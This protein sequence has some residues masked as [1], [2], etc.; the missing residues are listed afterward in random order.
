MKSNLTPAKF[1]TFS[2]AT[3]FLSILGAI[4]LGEAFLRLG[5]GIQPWQNYPVAGEPVIH[6]PDAVLGWRNRPGNYVFSLTSDSGNLVKMSFVTDG[7]R[8]TDVSRQAR[9]RKI[10]ILGCSLTQGWTISDDETYA[11]KLQARFP[12]EEVSNYGTGGYGTYQSLLLLERLLSKPGPAPGIVVYGFASFHE[13]RNV[14]AWYWLKLLSMFSHRGHIGVPYCDLDLTI[15][16]LRRHPPE[17]YPN[18]PF[19]RSL[20][21]FVLAEESFA[22]FESRQRVSQR[23]MVTEQLLLEMGRLCRDKG[24]RLLVA[25]L[26][27]ELGTTDYRA[28]LQQ[29]GLQYA[30]CLHPRY[31][32]PGFVAVRD[33]HPNE[34]MNE[35]WADQIAS[36]VSSLKSIGAGRETSSD[37]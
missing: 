18:W 10:V 32:S 16:G 27:Q 34:R 3:S 8:V 35:F 24:V 5:A 6:E 17:T 12:N 31:G 9:Q 28:F 14:A 30:D 22:R 23:R 13:D 11:W 37:K 36:A 20:A 15:G 19:K 4:L 26:A 7:S 29:T 21:T 2:L 33:G 25:L 1:I